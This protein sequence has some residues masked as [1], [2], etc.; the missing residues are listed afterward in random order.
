MQKNVL[1]LIII[2][3]MLVAFS[4]S[5]IFAAPP[6]GGYEPGE[7]L[8]PSCAPGDA[9]CI[10][11]PLLAQDEGVDL[12]GNVLKLNFEGA[13][14]SSAIASGVVT[15]TISGGGSSPIA[16]G[17]SNTLYTPGLGAGEGDTV[18]GHNIF[19]GESA[20][21]NA[22]NAYSSNFFGEEA[23]VDATNAYASN[24][25]GSAA[26]YEATNAYHSNFIG[27]QA[28]NLATN[29]SASNFFGPSAGDSATD[30]N[31]SNFFGNFAGASATNASYS[32]FIGTQAGNN[33]TNASYATFIG[34]NAGQNDTVNNTPSDSSILIG[35]DTSTGG[36]S[37]SIGLGAGATNTSANQLLIDDSY[38]Y[39]SLR[40]VNY[41]LPTADGSSG[42]VLTTDGSGV[43]TWEAAGG[44]SQWTTTGS[45]IYYNTGNVGVGTNNPQASLHVEG[46]LL[47]E[48]GLTE[49][50]ITGIM[51]DESTNF[52]RVRNTTDTSDRFTLQGDGG[53]NWGPGGVAGEDTSLRRL[54]VGVLYTDNDFIVNENL[55]IGTNTPVTQLDMYAEVP[56]AAADT[57]S[58]DNDP[59]DMFVQGDYAY[60]TTTN[61]TAGAL[62]IFDISNPANIVEMGSVS[63]PDAVAVFVSGRYA[64]VLAAD[65]TNDFHIVDV[66]DPSA[67]AVI[68]TLA[69]GTNPAQIVVSGRYAYVV[70]YSNTAFQI[71]D[72]SNPTDPT[73]VSSTALPGSTVTFKGLAI[74]GS[75]AYIGA[76]NGT[77]QIYNISNPASPTSIGSV[78]TSFG[79]IENL[80]Y[81]NNYLYTVQ[82]SRLEIFDVSDP[83]VPV[84]SSALTIDSAA[85][86]ISVRGNFAYVVGYTTDAMEVFDVSDPS[87]PVSIGSVSAGG[88]PHSIETDGRF[89]YVADQGTNSIRSFDLGGAYITQI[90]TGALSTGKLDAEHVQSIQLDVRG[91]L[92]VGAGGIF[93]SGF[94]TV[95]PGTTTSQI[96]LKAG[97][98]YVTD[99]S[100]VLRL[101]DAN[102]ACDFTAN[103]GSPS[104]GSD[105]TLK[106]DITSIESSLSKILGLRPTTYHWFDDEE[107][108]P[109][110]HG[111]IAQEV[112][113]V[114]PHLVTESTW[115]D[116]TTRK[117]LNT[118]GMVPYIVG[119]IKDMYTEF[120]TNFVTKRIQVQEEICFDEV[121]LTKERVLELLQNANIESNS[122]NQEEE[123]LENTDTSEE[124]IPEET[125][126]DI[127]Q[128][129]ET[130]EQTPVT[131]EPI[132]E[133]ETETQNPENQETTEENIEVGD[134]SLDPQEPTL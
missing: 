123:I 44:S 3:C 84:S 107:S 21:S 130:E 71:F 43:L 82:D 2:L 117:F 50:R 51:D 52:I 118:G 124:T 31:N 37:N 27:S 122:V 41:E 112:E 4:P 10:V 111:F 56:S 40:G 58:L 88:N 6:A 12:S 47:L 87:A 30:A 53:M 61:F 121:C 68:A 18:D 102:S 26:G 65:S 28:G 69:T 29:A 97:S 95:A 83:S 79:F 8:D 96:S 55:G 62:E 132:V 19:F 16:L 74:A 38:I 126:E 100:T 120:T 67:P 101:Q 57:T 72:I 7:T 33:A 1:K 115:V 34:S 98:S 109:L 54:D 35:R 119:A 48:Q 78:A 11:T 113:T 114:L 106:K 73:S 77:L 92:N 76:P 129:P 46:D 128:N 42:D 63:I 39:L 91:G 20:G 13:G 81:Q 64:Y 90:E 105:E 36:F 89:A 80:E 49:A 131:E 32:T 24:F 104:C 108:D 86:D 85:R 93:S 15:V 127:S 25:L 116:G 134:D 70:S 133:E 125:P 99:G 22:L 59:Y 75:Y 23:G 5:T 9:D 66:Q 14:V 103:T 60:V 17:S 45:D 94:L 110:Q